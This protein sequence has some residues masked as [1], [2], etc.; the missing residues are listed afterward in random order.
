MF[1][2]PPDFEQMHFICND[3]GHMFQGRDCEKGPQEMLTGPLALL[4]SRFGLQGP[5]CPECGSR[6]AKKNMFVRY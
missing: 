5:M 4:L 3:C 2:F 6:N 1:F